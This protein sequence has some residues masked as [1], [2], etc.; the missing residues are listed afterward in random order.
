MRTAE[1]TARIHDLSD[2]RGAHATARDL[3]PKTTMASPTIAPL[4]QLPIARLD[5]AEEVRRMR[6]HPSRR[7]ALTRTVLH[8]ARLRLMLVCLRRGA[9]IPERQIE[10]ALTIQAIDGRVVVTVLESSFDLLPGQ[11]LAIE[12]E[13]PHAIVAIEPSAV[14]ITISWN[15]SEAPTEVA[16]S[17]GARG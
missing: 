7:P 5:L 3:P 10:G 8:G 4:V 16:G 14:L 13:V 9:H 1:I 2:G 15:P 11:I 6:D 12:H 17:G